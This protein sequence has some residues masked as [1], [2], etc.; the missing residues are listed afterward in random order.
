M[1]RRNPFDEI[2]EMFEQMS[3]QFGQFGQF[4]Q[5]NVPATQ[6]LSVDLAD[7]DDE[8]EVTAD[9][10]GYD[11]EDIDLTVADRTLRISAERDESMKED[12]GNYLRRERRR[13]SVSRSL[14]LPEDVEEE[15]ASAAYTNGVL[16]VTLPKATSDED[17][18]SIDIN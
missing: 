14:S 9:L 10:P 8:F 17:S 1:S 16:T 6:S 3:D 15:E 7:H 4:D 18:R 11:R 12:D 2:E 5:M 13:H